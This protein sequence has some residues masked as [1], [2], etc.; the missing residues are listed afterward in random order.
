MWG[1]IKIKNFSQIRFVIVHGDIIPQNCIWY[2]VFCVLGGNVN[3]DFHRVALKC[4]VVYNAGVE[5][6]SRWV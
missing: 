3:D 1:K 4:V 2:I 5:D 6:V